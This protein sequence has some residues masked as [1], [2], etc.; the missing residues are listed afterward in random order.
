MSSAARSTA[1]RTRPCACPATGRT[2]NGH[3]RQIRKAAE[4]INAAE[5][6]VL[7]AGGGVISSGAS[8]QLR[9]L[10]RKGRIPVTTTLMGL[11][12]F[13]ESDPLALHMLGMHG[14]AY[15]NYAVQNCDLLIAVGARFDDRITGKH[16]GL[17]AARQ[18]RPHRHRPDLHRQER[19]GAHT[20]RR[21]TR[22]AC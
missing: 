14:A 16:R 11:G 1:S 21:A 7:Y 18:H 22:P 15:A 9:A 3:A 2:A 19:A 5:R 13:P 20:R 12:A 4:A 17:R 6:P 8:E 10:A